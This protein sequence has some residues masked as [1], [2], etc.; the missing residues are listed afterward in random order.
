MF[1]LGIVASPN[2]FSKSID[3]LNG[4]CHNVLIPTNERQAMSTF[5]MITLIA[6]NPGFLTI[7]AAIIKSKRTN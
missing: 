5:L 4:M 3:T 2:I 1:M 6:L 7:T